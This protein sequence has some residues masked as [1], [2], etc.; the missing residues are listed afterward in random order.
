MVA[1][2]E[3]MGIFD[4]DAHVKIQYTECLR[5]GSQEQEKGYCKKCRDELSNGMIKALSVLLALILVGALVFG[6]IVDMTR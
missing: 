5:C 2:L 4:D 6:L 3:W 1:G